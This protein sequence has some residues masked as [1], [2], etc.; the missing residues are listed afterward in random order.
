M[1]TI[2]ITI[3]VGVLSGGVSGAVLQGWFATRATRWNA[4]LEAY[5][6]FGRAIGELNRVLTRWN[7]GHE[8]DVYPDYID[9]ART[10]DIARTDLS[11]LC[12]AD[13]IHI[14]SKL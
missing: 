12:S 13:A 11:Y 10:L 2:V 14:A 1:G 6:A 3:L 7:S 4:R 5:Q 9:A 8:E